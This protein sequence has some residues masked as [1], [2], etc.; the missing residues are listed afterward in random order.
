M[1]KERFGVNRGGDS[2]GILLV[3]DSDELGHS[4]TLALSGGGFR[5]RLLRDV[6]L[7][8][9]MARGD[10]PALILLGS[11][12]ARPPAL[13]V[14][15]RLK[16]DD[17]LH[18]IP[19]VFVGSST[20]VVDRLEAF[21]AGGC[22][23]ILFPF[24]PKDLAARVGTHV[25]LCGI[26]EKATD[27]LAARPSEERVESEE[28][29]HQAQKLEAV[30]RLAAGIAHEINTPA[31]FVTDNVYFLRD[32]FA[33]I[34]CI[35]KA[36]KSLTEQDPPFTQ[37]VRDMRSLLEAADVSFLVT[38][39]PKAFE[40]TVEG[41]SRITRLVGAMKEFSRPSSAQK[42]PVDLNRAIE[43]T[44]MVS[45]NEWKYVATLTTDLQAD[46]PAVSCLGD[47]INQVVLNLIV[48]AAHAIGE[49]TPEGG[50]IHGTIAISTRSMGA[51]VEIRIKDSGGG[52]PESIRRRI[53]EPFFT[54]KPIGKGTGQG[55]AIARAIVVDK[56]QGSLDFETETGV[57]TTFIIRLPFDGNTS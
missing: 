24:E 15:R 37:C 9:E 49:R 34:Q 3:A 54:T 57:G 44:I 26:G 36:A 23:Y 5:P 52:I 12:S 56:H 42:A 16:R 53:F 32:A 47:E 1:C 28:K 25:Q 13:E 17:Q 31:Q 33:D 11:A 4:L 20:T 45:R 50:G 18:S 51:M 22:D 27:L 2:A 6:E 14:C 19:V 8:A 21:R 43:S 48:N 38:E 40:Q 46:L 55:L 10:P 41:L 29:A 7:V 30:G 35:I 39:T